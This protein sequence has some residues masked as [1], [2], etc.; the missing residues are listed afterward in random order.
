[1]P[2]PSSIADLST[3]AGSNS[4]A[5]TEAPSTLDNYQR[6]HASFI[7]QL[8]AVIG[9]ATDANIPTS[10]PTES[11]LAGAVISQSG[12]SGTTAGTSTAYTLTPSTALAAYTANSTFWVTFHTA[13]G[14]SP[15]LQISGLSTPPNLVRQTD[16]GTYT[17]IAAGE[18]P[19]S[20]RSRVTLLSAS[21]A[22]VE[23][24]P[25][26]INSLDT[27]RIN[28]ASA[29]TVDLTSLA[30]NTRHINITGTTA[31]GNFTVKAG[32]T[33]FVRFSGSLTLSYSILLNTQRLADITTAAGDT[34][35]IR[36]IV[37]NA[38]EII[39]YV[40]A[41]PN[42]I[43]VG[44]TWQDVSGSRSESTNYTNSTG[45]PI[46]VN[47][48]SASTSGSPT[49][50]ILSITVDGVVAAYCPSYTANTTQGGFASVTVPDGSVY[51][52]VV[53]NGNIGKWVEL[54]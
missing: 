31:I 20:H 26:A 51:S 10:W 48:N 14:A 6:A 3:S 52:A 49:V 29:S 38:I 50:T 40:P 21:Q 8:R 24:M 43:G 16:T 32:R 45:R 54:R 2:V 46:Q 15:T 11:D 28:V 41:T 9:G 17:N 37:D 27:V 25:P 1:M 34:C 42:A 19:A 30:P 18:I 13:S 33:Y 5:G 44:Q 53:S 47:I 22:L 4:P 36:A 23:D 7:A 12:N 39:S 35:I